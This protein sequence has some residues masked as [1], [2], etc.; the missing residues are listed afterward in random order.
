VWVRDWEHVGTETVLRAA[1]LPHARLTTAV[2]LFRAVP[3][4][5]PRDLLDGTTNVLST[6]DAGV[7]RYAAGRPPWRD[8]PL[9]WDRLYALVSN[10]RQVLGAT[11]QLDADT[12]T[13]LARDAVRDEARAYLLPSGAEGWWAEPGCAAST[14]GPDRVHAEDLGGARVAFP[15]DDPVARD[16][17]GRLVARADAELASLVGGVPGGGARAVPLTA[18]RYRTELVAGVDLAFIA[19][20]PSRPLDPCRAVAGLAASAPWLAQTPGTITANAVAPL[21]ETRGYLLVR[22]IPVVHLDWDGGAWLL[23]DRR[24]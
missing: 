8:I 21:V 19:R 6:R 2:L 22:G 10:A 20:I 12:R 15:G 9:A 4:A 1:P 5:D 13:A 3:G 11:A 14:V 7:L 24:P 23:G 16:L 18:E 17:A